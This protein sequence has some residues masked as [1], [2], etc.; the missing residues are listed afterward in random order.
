[1]SDPFW[2]VLLL[3]ITFA[4]GVLMSEMWRRR[5]KAN[6]PLVVDEYQIAISEKKGFPTF[7]LRFLTSDGKSRTF[8]LAPSHAYILSN[9]LLK[10]NAQLSRQEQAKKVG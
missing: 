10:T 4:V 6:E 1:M 9:E 2:G 8:E 7:L 5:S 3:G